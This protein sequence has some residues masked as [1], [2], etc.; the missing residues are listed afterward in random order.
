MVRTDPEW[1]ALRVRDYGVG[2][3]GQTFD[4]AGTNGKQPGVGLTG[5]KERVQEQGGTL[6]VRS[7]ETGTEIVV[8]IPVASHMSMSLGA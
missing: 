3:P 2:I 1:V 7:D 5:M 8:R 6:E 4:G